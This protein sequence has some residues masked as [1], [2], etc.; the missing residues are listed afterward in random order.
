[1]APNGLRAACCARA[2]RSRCC[3]RYV[4]YVQALGHGFGTPEVRKWRMV[5][6]GARRGMGQ[7]AR[8]RPVVAGL[9]VPPHLRGHARAYY[10]RPPRPV[11]THK[12]GSKMAVRKIVW[13]TRL[14]VLLGC[15]HYYQG[16]A[17]GTP[18]CP[19][20]PPSADV[21]TALT[22]AYRAADR[23]CYKPRHVTRAKIAVRAVRHLHATARSG[24]TACPHPDCGCEAVAATAWAAYRAAVAATAWA[25]YRAVVVASRD[26]ARPASHRVAMAGNRAC[27]RRLVQGALSRQ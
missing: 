23:A 8:P 20:C 11:G 13:P 9:Y 6:Q 15:A 3:G 14:Q 2:V 21:Y 22:A 1:M 17:I 4:R 12:G 19:A 7:G 26:G 18:A 24:A 10:W 5:G 27:A 25:V 16:H